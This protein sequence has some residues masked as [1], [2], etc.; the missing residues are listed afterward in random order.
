MSKLRARVRGAGLVLAVG[1]QVLVCTAAM[2]GPSPGQAGAVQLLLT[3][4][5]SCP[6]SPR[7]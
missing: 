2:Q 3:P 7:L 5:A 4:E 6:L 1:S